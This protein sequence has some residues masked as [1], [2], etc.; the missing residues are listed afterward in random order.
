METSDITA[1]IHKLI[2]AEHIHSLVIKLN[3]FN[4]QVEHI[5]IILHENQPSYWAQLGEIMEKLDILTIADEYGDITHLELTIDRS[6][7][8]PG[9]DLMGEAYFLSINMDS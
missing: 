9:T 5:S 1:I 7:D 2:P 6:Y 3:Q 4:K 8:I